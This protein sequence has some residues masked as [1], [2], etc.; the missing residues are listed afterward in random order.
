MKISKINLSELSL[1]LKVVPLGL[2]EPLVFFSIVLDC[3]IFGVEE[4]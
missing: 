4:P 1:Q 3:K 2:E